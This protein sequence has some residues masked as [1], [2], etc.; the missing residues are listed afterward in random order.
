VSAIEIGRFE[1]LPSTPALAAGGV[2]RA[3]S[4]AAPAPAAAVSVMGD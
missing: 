4:C 3:R 2:M 1:T